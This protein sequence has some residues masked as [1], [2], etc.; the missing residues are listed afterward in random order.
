MEMKRLES[1][2]SEVQQNNASE[3]PTQEQA[4]KAMR[5]VRAVHAAAQK[6]TFAVKRT[7]VRS[8]RPWALV[9]AVRETAYLRCAV[10]IRNPLSPW[11]RS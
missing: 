6:A 4:D 8:P 5:L 11:R 9:S 2:L 3:L 10:F 1:P 7:G